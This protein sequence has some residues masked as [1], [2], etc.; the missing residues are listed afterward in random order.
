MIRILYVDDDVDFQE[1]VR[2]NV[3]Q[4][5]GFEIVTASSGNEAIGLFNQ[6]RRYDLVISDY[7][8]PNGSGHDLFRYLTDNRISGLFILFTS[9][10]ENAEI[11]S[12][13]E[14][15]RPVKIVS[16]TEIRNLASAIVLA[17]STGRL[18]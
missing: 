13:F 1:L 10:S 15:G 14:G 6:G 16:K 2:D 7:E 9:H 3:R 18:S 11:R 4:R 5:L 12:K 17:F 8:M